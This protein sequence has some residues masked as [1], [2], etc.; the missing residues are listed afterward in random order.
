[1]LDTCDTCEE[2]ETGVMFVNG[3]TLCYEC[4]VLTADTEEVEEDEEEVL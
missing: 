1:M 3:L 4:A 2:Q